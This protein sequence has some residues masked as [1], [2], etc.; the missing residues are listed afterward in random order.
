M[1]EPRSVSDKCVPRLMADG[2]H[3][4]IFPYRC[5]ISSSEVGEILGRTAT[6]VGHLFNKKKLGGCGVDGGNLN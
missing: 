1:I 2:G 3:L 4:Q 5:S 6:G